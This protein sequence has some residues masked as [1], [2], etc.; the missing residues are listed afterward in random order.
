MDHIVNVA[1]QVREGTEQAVDIMNQLNES[2][3]TVNGAVR[4][5]S[6]STQTTAENIQAQ[7]VM[8]Q[9]IQKA[10][11]ETMERSAEMVET[12]KNPASSMRRTRT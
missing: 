5:I 7:T 4:D 11:G 9:N 2:T 8:T 10:I 12:A 3:D 6:D 1:E